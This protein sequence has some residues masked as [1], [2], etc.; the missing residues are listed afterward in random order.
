MFLPC[1]SQSK[2][3]IVAISRDEP[4]CLLPAGSRL[5]AALVITPDNDCYSYS[6]TNYYNFLHINNTEQSVYTMVVYTL[7]LSI[8]PLLLKFGHP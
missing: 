6:T 2:G 1:S 7:D 3:A 4:S 8:A 5:L